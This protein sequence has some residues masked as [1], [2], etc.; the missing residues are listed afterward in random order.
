MKRYL[1]LLAIALSMTV[2]AWAASSII[3]TTGS[4]C[5][6]ATNCLVVNLPQDKGGATLTL[7]GTWTGT[8]SFEATG[9]GGA[10][11]VAVNATPLNSTTAATSATANGTWQVNVSAFTGIRMRASATMSGAATATIVFSAA[12]ARM[13]GGGGGGGIGN[14]TGPASSITGELANFADTTGKLLGESGVFKQVFDIRAYGATTGAGDNSTAIQNAINDAIAANGCTYIPAGTWNYATTLTARSS[15]TVNG[16]HLGACLTG[17][18]GLC[19]N[20]GANPSSSASSC[21]Q[22]TGTGSAVSTRDGTTLTYNPNW[23]HLGVKCGNVANCAI[24]MD[25]AYANTAVFED[26]STMDGTGDTGYG[27]GYDFTKAWDLSGASGVYM[28]HANIMDSTTG[29]YLN[30]ASNIYLDSIDAYEV[31]NCFA[32]AGG[33]SNINIYASQNLESCDKVLAFD[34]DEAGNKSY[35]QLSFHNNRVL[36]DPVAPYV[37]A[38]QILLSATTTSN[39]GLLPAIDIYDNTITWATPPAYAV[40]A[41]LAGSG[42]TYGTLNIHD[43][44]I[45]GI[46]SGLCSTTSDAKMYCNAARNFGLPATTDP[47][48]FEFGNIAGFG[49]AAHAWDVPTTGHILA[50]VDNTYNIGAVGA[51]RPANVYI[52]TQVT[53]PTFNGA[54]VGNATTATALSGSTSRQ[55]N[56][57][58]GQTGT[59]T[60]LT[61]FM[62]LAIVSAGANGASVSMPMLNNGTMSGCTMRCGITLTGT[63][64]RTFTLQ[65]IHSGT[66]AACGAP[67]T[68]TIVADSTHC[69]LNT[70]VTDSTN[71]CAFV[72]GDLLYWQIVPTN[73]ATADNASGACSY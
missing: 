52:G 24:G 41:S 45:G 27:T 36:F 69:N 18:G 35:A 4:T 20:Y 50:H 21:L 66:P 63:M 1:L 16:G 67:G 34:A 23:H 42:T 38:N 19:N 13:N 62:G 64:T 5:S 39:H 49:Q 33:G 48:G 71:S 61:Q 32:F 15:S 43:N 25:M 3:T 73:S 56:F 28:I 31:T 22:Y 6:P 53:A 68:V 46:T 11:W 12:S 8:I 2:Q 10:T 30:G 59:S 40:V 54:L 14:V 72:S 60:T 47:N 9:D 70:T 29:F 57:G 37:P 7:S 65:K 26:V 44:T 51:N 58:N 17:V 55:W